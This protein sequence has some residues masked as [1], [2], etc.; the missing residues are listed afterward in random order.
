[1]TEAEKASIRREMDLDNE[2]FE[3]EMKRRQVA[4]EQRFLQGWYAL[5]ESR[6]KREVKW[7]EKEQTK[8]VA[9]EQKRSL[10]DDLY[11]DND[12]EM[13]KVHKEIYQDATPR[14][15]VS[16][17]DVRSDDVFDQFP[18]DLSETEKRRN[19]KLIESLECHIRNLNARE[20]QPT[21]NA[22]GP[23]NT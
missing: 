9:Q 10:S 6:K 21:Y 8:S 14:G 19:D 15:E 22:I 12:E 4:N 7:D 3:K 2:E 11:K 16:L 1:M 5:N 17:P 18:E 23:V 20:M 13:N